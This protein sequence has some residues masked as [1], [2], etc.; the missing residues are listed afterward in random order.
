MRCY[1]TVEDKRDRVLEMYESRVE[2]KYADQFRH[3]VGASYLSSQRTVSGKFSV[4]EMTR[5]FGITSALI[6]RV[7]NDWDSV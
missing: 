6:D 5:I 4:L 2:W 3:S 7:E 1:R